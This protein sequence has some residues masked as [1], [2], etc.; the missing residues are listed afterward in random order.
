MRKQLSSGLTFFY[1]FITPLVF[2]G[3]L[4]FINFKIRGN[5][6]IED[7]FAINFIY[8]IIMTPIIILTSSD[9][10]KVYYDKNNL[11]VSNFFTEQEYKIKSIVKVERWLIFY[12]KIYIE[13][14]N[15]KI[16]V[17]FIPPQTG[18]IFSSF[19]C[20]K[21]IMEFKEIINNSN[22]IGCC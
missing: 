8:V 2:L 19:N 11:F 5:A 13:I 16:K 15:R 12:Y 6:S 9:L 7:L 1:K 18:N 3:F 17:K 4:L 22:E 20:S 21:S 10:K 14:G